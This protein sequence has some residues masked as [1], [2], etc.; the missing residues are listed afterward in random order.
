MMDFILGVVIIVGFLIA[1][2]GA[3]LTVQDKERAFWR[4]KK[5]REL[6]TQMQKDILESEKGGRP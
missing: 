3:Y 1:L 2:H 5:S 6:H 4:D